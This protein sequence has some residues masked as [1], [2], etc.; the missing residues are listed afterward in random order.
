MKEVSIRFLSG[1]LYVSL[2][3]FSLFSSSEWYLVLIFCLAT[4]TVHEFLKLISMKGVVPYILVAIPF[5]FI[6][7]HSIDYTLLYS[8]LFFSVLMNIFLFRDVML[9]DK[10]TFFKSKPYLY[11]IFYLVSGFIFLTLIPFIG[12]SFQP[13][14]VL[15]IFIL[16]WTNDTFAYLI[17]KKFGKKKLKEKISPKKTIE[18]CIGGLLAVL[19]AGVIIFNTTLL[20]SAAFWLILAL[21]VSILG[22]TGDLIQSKFK[23]LAGV[24]D[25]GRM[26]PG[27]GGIYDRLDSIIFA[28]PFIYSFIIFINYVS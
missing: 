24:K 26:M 7:F 22:T 9:L 10:I 2:V 8:L 20:Y 16:T 13:K 11:I 5:Y 3:L 18:G 15:G 17:G 21:L 25:S 6:A 1:V 12:S 19:I 28:S 14:L 27:H 4:I 23:R